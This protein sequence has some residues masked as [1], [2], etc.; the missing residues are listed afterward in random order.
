[1]KTH[2]ETLGIS[3]SASASQIRASYRKLAKLYHPDVAQVGHAEAEKQIREINVA[4][5]VLS[6]PRTR[7]SYDAGLN[8]D[9]FDR[10]AEP[11]HC[12]NCGKPTTY[13]RVNR[14][15]QVCVVCRGSCL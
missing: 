13:W 15:P 2:Y 8:K 14:K 4:Y 3:K 1:M 12:S 11:E 6:K 10:A 5:S 7:S 9:N